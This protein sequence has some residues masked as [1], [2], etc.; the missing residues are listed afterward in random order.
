MSSGRDV[1]FGYDDGVIGDLRLE[2]NR[3]AAAGHAD[4]LRI[5]R[6]GAVFAD[7]ALR[8][9]IEANRTAD[10]AGVEESRDFPVRLLIKPEADS[11]AAFFGFEAVQFAIVNLLQRDGDL[12]VD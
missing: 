4:R 3:I 11:D 9:F 8:S 12:A 2:R 10:F 1:G 5:D 7:H 6:R